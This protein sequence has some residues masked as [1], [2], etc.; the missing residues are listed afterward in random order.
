[1]HVAES[2]IGVRELFMPG[3]ERI[4]VSDEKYPEINRP[5][6]RQQYAHAFAIV[7]RLGIYRFNAG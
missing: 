2:L 5:I 1:M 4:I 3:L 7:R 6:T